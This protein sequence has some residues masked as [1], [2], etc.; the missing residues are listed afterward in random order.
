MKKKIKKIQMTGR[1]NNR[2]KIKGNEIVRQMSI[3]IH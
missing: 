3:I 2:I 1:K